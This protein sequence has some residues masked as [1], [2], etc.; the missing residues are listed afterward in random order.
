MSTAGARLERAALALCGTP[1]RLRG[2]D[3]R[4]GLDCV[5]LVA[6][7]LTAIGR[8]PPPLPDYALRHH[9][10]AGFA[11]VLRGCG[12]RAAAGPVRGGDVLLLR[13]GPGQLHV[14]IRTAGGGL[15]HAHAALGRVV[16]EPD[17]A[18]WPVIEAWR[19]D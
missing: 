15:I 5:G 10:L 11:P 3:P 16:C 9:D 7:A 2:R 6:A 12:L 14:G 13:P 4:H 1:F 18:S 17:R 19:I 8:R